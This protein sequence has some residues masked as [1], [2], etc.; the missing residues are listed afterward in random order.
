MNIDG[1]IAS[2]VVKHFTDMNEPILSVHDSFICREQ[3]KDELTRVMNEVV[4]ETL[5]GYIVG[6]KANKIVVDLS[7]R[8]TNGIINVSK[9]KD[10]YFNRAKDEYRCEGYL[11]RWSE[12]RYWLHM[13]EDPIYTST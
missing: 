8:I 2:K 13:I 5:Q 11:S 1:A 6:I 12:H 7:S 9:M 4:G 10:L 3:F